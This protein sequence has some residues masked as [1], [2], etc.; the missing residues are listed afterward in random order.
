[1]FVAGINVRYVKVFDL[2]PEV[3]DDALTQEMG[4]F[5]TVQQVVKKKFPANLGLDHWFTG[6]RGVH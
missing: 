3:S 6:E 4:K 1:M 2:P 5:G